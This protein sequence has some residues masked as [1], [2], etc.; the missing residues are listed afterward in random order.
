MNEIL[1]DIKELKALINQAKKKPMTKLGF[2]ALFCVFIL[3]TSAYV[4]YLLGA[5]YFLLPT[6]AIWQNEIVCH[7]I[8]GLLFCTDMFFLIAISSS[9]TI[10]T[11]AKLSVMY[12]PLNYIFD[13][14]IENGFIYTIL[15]PFLYIIA[16]ELVYCKTRRIR[17]CIAT[18]LNFIILGIMIT[19]YQAITMPI[20]LGLDIGISANRDIGVLSKVLY[21]IDLLLFLFII[22]YMKGSVM[23]GRWMERIF[24]PEEIQCSKHDSED[25]AADSWVKELNL[26][27]RIVFMVLL[28]A[29]QLFQLLLILVVCKIGNVYL[30]GAIILMSFGAA[31]MIIKRRW[32]SKSTAVCTLLTVITF[33]TAARISIPAQYS[34]ICPVLIGMLISYSLYR[35]AIYTEKK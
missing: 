16:V 32:H 22:L 17:H 21:S 14:F 2:F 12:I 3:F 23:H 25:D 30:E 33:Y 8:T 19:S 24:C 6:G 9:V 29:F 10:K 11:A 4:S 34:I 18:I 26:G 5:R 20:K 13:A 15:L 31:G 35:I 27:K 1:N 28:Y 7:I